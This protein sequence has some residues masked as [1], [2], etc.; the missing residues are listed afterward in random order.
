VQPSQLDRELKRKQVVFVDAQASQFLD[1]PEPLAQR[2]GMNEQGPRA[3][4]DAAPLRQVS[5]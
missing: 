5:L 2:V 4:D 3:L 1:P